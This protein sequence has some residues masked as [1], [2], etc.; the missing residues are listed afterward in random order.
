[1]VSLFDSNKELLIVREEALS[2][3][4]EMALVVDGTQMLAQNK[5]PHPRTHSD[6]GFTWVKAYRPRRQ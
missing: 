3:S 2:S 6:L 1:M 5:R 4:L